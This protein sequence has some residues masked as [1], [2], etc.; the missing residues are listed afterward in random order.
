VIS[1]VKEKD[2]NNIGLEVGNHRE[3]LLTQFR[4]SIKSRIEQVEINL[5][6]DRVALAYIEQEILKEKENFQKSLKAKNV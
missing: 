2:T 5:E 1:I 6:I 4:D 3:N